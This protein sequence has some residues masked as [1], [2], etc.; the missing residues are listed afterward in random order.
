MLRDFLTLRQLFLCTSVSYHIASKWMLLIKVDKVHRFQTVVGQTDRLRIAISQWRC[1]VR[2]G[3]RTLNRLC[4]RSETVSVIGSQVMTQ[5]WHQWVHDNPRR[6]LDLL[7]PRRSLADLHA[8]R[9][10]IA[11]ADWPSIS[12]DSIKVVDSPPSCD[13]SQY[14]I[15]DVT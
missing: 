4:S 6:R 8:S 13:V 1:G 14:V 11:G 5:I 2:K 3:G 9:D 10:L 7:A 12:R 15:H